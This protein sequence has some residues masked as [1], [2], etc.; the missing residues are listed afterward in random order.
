MSNT[1]AI[2]IRVLLS[3]I[4]FAA[5]IFILYCSTVSNGK[6]IRKM[7]EQERIALYTVQNFSNVKK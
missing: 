6:D 7:H 4:A 2:T 1:R 5:R 3:I